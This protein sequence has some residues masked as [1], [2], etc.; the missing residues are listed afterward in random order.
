MHLRSLGSLALAAALLFCSDSTGPAYE[1]PADAPIALS[2]NYNE[3]GIIA[4][5]AGDRTVLDTIYQE[6]GFIGAVA[7]APDYQRLVFVRDNRL[8]T[9]NRDG[10]GEAALTLQSQAFLVIGSVSWS[11]DGSRIAFS[12]R[13]DLGCGLHILELPARSL[14]FVGTNREFDNCTFSVAWA[15]DGRR[16]ALEERDVQAR[17]II[18]VMRHDGEGLREVTRPPGAFSSLNWSPDGERIVFVSDELGPQD[19]WSV[20]MDDGV[21]R[22]ITNATDSIDYSP[23]FSP[24]GESIAFVREARFGG[25]PGVRTVPSDGGTPRMLFPLGTIMALH[26]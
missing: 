7:W 25:N 5:L 6:F 9:I 8:F 11:P 16:I 3:V 17:R 10:S 2:I 19:V 21:R 18:A 24:D 12:A 4:I 13:S 23:A 1:R 15:P 20:D 26:W 22:R 14:R